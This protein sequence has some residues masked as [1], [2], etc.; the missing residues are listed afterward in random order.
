MALASF[1]V[2][3]KFALVNWENISGSSGFLQELMN[4]HNM[5]NTNA[6][7]KSFFI[8]IYF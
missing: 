6:L 4:V 7:K 2:F 3:G 8:F 1:S 5:D